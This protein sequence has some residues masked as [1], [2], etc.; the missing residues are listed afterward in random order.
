MIRIFERSQL[1]FDCQQAQTPSLSPEKVI[2]YANLLAIADRLMFLKSQT[3][4]NDSP[5]ALTKADNNGFKPVVYFDP[6]DIKNVLRDDRYFR[7]T[8]ATQHRLAEDLLKYWDET[9]ANQLLNQP[10][11]SLSLDKWRN[12]FSSGLF[13]DECEEKNL[14][15]DF[16]NAP[17]LQDFISS[18]SAQEYAYL[19][20]R[21]KAK[22]PNEKLTINGVEKVFREIE[23]ASDDSNILPPEVIQ[24]RKM[25]LMMKGLL[26]HQ[27][28]F[29]ISSPKELFEAGSRMVS[30]AGGNVNA[31]SQQEMW[32]RLWKIQGEHVQAKFQENRP[33]LDSKTQA[34]GHSRWSID[35]DGLF[36][37][38]PS[39][40]AIFSGGLSAMERLAQ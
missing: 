34:R 2:A 21:H 27:H 14:K 13:L 8:S 3:F 15:I 35:E 38:H 26:L 18:Q 9:E 1:F 11:V 24:Q 23:I 33:G 6:E 31:L 19:R 16:S 10:R 25:H 12:D 28:P 4:S 32:Q 40:C 22:F 37:V 29:I 39:R 17:S 5:Y 36:W 20:D 7:L 30:E